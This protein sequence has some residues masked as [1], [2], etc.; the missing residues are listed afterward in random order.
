MGD[1]DSVIPTAVG[2]VFAHIVVAVE[3]TEASRE[4]RTKRCTWLVRTLPS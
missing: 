3:G 1:P 4:A 2:D